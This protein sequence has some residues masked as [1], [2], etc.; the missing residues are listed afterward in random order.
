MIAVTVASIFGGMNSY[1]SESSCIETFNFRWTGLVLA[2]HGL[3]QDMVG[4]DKLYRYHCVHAW[5]SCDGWRMEVS[6]RL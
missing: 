3:E 6:W 1:E 4:A 5:R 2:W